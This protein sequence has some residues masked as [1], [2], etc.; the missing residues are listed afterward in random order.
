MPNVG[1]NPTFSA[2]NTEKALDYSRAFLFS[3]RHVMI[4]RNKADRIKQVALKNEIEPILS[5]VSF[6]TFG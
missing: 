1:S 5:R 2:S 4:A 3:I 6:T